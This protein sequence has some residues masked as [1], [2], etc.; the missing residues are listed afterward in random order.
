MAD[1]CE[2]RMNQLRARRVYECGVD[3]T[4]SP[5]RRPGDSRVLLNVIEWLGLKQ[6]LPVQSA[7]KVTLEPRRRVLLQHLM[8]E[9]DAFSGNRLNLLRAD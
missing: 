4:K 2:G 7:Q 3:K 9:C 1:R 5:A 6:T 8:F